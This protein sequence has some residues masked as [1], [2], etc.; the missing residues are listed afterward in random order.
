M[1]RTAW[2]CAGPALFAP[3]VRFAV[4]VRLAGAVFFR[5]DRFMAAFMLLCKLWHIAVQNKKH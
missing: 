2:L 1:V 5:G 4:P 3:P